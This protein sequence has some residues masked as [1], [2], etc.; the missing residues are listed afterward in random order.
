MIK[1]EFCTTE[2]KNIIPLDGKKAFGIDFF[3]AA[4][5]P[6]CNRVS[7]SIGGFDTERLNMVS[8]MLY[9]LEGKDR[10]PLDTLIEYSQ[11][12]YYELLGNEK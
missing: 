3:G 5:C 4:V 1:C 7:F 8:E 12:E 9:S 2:L 6:E 11:K 10:E